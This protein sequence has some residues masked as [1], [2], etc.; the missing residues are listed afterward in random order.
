MRRTLGLFG[1]LLILFILNVP[2]RSQDLSP[3]Q[4]DYWQ[5]FVHYKID[6]TLDPEKHLLTGKETVLYRNNSPD[7]LHKIYFHLYP[8]A[9]KDE[10]T[11]LMREGR[12]FFPFRRFTFKPEDGGYIEIRHF[13]IRSGKGDPTEVAF[14]VEDTTLEADLPE[15]LPPGGEIEITMEFLEKVRKHRGRAGYRGRQYDFGQWY[16]KV[17]VYDQEGWHTEP[18][19]AIGEFYGEFGTFDV[20][21]TVP[22]DYIVGATGVVVDGDPGWEAVYRDTSVAE[23]QWTKKYLQAKKELR[24]K[25]QRERK[26]RTVTFHAE[27]VHDF[28]W[29]TSPNFV[30]E[31]GEY[32]GIPIHVL[33]RSRAG[34]RWSK[35]VLQRAHDTLKWL[36]ERFG[37]YPYPQ[38][39]IIHGLMGG[40]MEYPMLV[41]NS[42]ES[43]G[44]ILH[45]VGHIYF[46]GILANNE[47]KEAWLDEGFTSFQTGWF[48][49]TKYGPLGYDPEKR[50]QRLPRLVRRFYPLR[51]MRESYESYLLNYMT[52][53]FNEPISRYAYK[54]RD[55]SSYR[56]N[57]YGKGALFFDMLRYVVGDQTW[58]KICRAYFDRWH[59]KHVNEERFRKVCEDVSG[60]DLGWFFRQWL[61]D[62]V[63]VDY[64]LGEVKK[65]KLPDGRYRTTVEVIRKDQGIMPVE[66]LLRTDRGDSLVQRWDGRDR[67][68]QLTFVTEARPTQVV[69]DPNNR[70]LD[71]NLLNNGFGQ[72]E[73]YPECPIV[74]IRGSRRAYLLTYR[75]SLWYNEIDGLRV[76]MKWKGRYMDREERLYVGLWYGTRSGELDFDLRYN[77]RLAPRTYLN[78]HTLK[79]EGRRMLSL[80]LWTSRSRSFTLPPWH[81]F[82]AG[83]QYSELTDSSYTLLQQKVGKRYVDVQTWELGRVLK[84]WFSYRFNTRGMKWQSGLHLQVQGAPRG[85]GSDWNFTTGSG[86]F[87]FRYSPRPIGLHLRLFG[88][89]K[90]SGGPIPLQDQFYAFGA[91]PSEAFEKFWLRSRGAFP[92]EVNFHLSGGGNLR[93]YYDHFIRGNR[94]IAANAEIRLDLPSRGMGRGPAFGQS[95]V[96]LVLF[97]DVGKI[98]QLQGEQEFKNKL[99]DAGFGLRWQLNLFGRGHT[100]R[101]DFPLFLTDPLP[102]DKKLEFRWV[103]GFGESF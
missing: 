1:I 2:S 53:G 60:M 93:G 66:V 59:F 44:L 18:F 31:R 49:E 20:T 100:L 101:V 75:P 56:A 13:A 55:P 4:E 11:V 96:S 26:Q 22:Y 54:F 65:Q 48:Q 28:A 40:G 25:A 32:D 9:Y 89:S 16:P 12:K 80:S 102:G 39:T 63:T 23:A 68:A 77:P 30:Y 34:N 62:S 103:V 7:T 21:I 43:E 84:W 61:H 69:V 45:E 14:K 27:N 98:W 86:E 91:N 81:Y 64:A 97:A 5:Q 35:V 6:V 36:S 78:G 95:R 37:R 67:R 47:Q 73:I 94:L 17:S 71:K 29:S 99:A 58:R 46:Y 85:M 88:G 92:A 52:S 38:L 82:F 8:N 19:H 15:P 72:I 79:L 41:M 33:Y 83:I 76:G 10:N 50:R 3:G 90:L 24:R 57:A 70:I 74:P 87:T 42:S 51:S